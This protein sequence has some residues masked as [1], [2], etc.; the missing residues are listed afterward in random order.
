MIHALGLS[1]ALSV[2]AAVDKVLDVQKPVGAAVGI[3]KDGKLVYEKYY[4]LRNLAKN[5]PVD[6]NTEFN[7]GSVTKQ[8]TASAI[9][10]L[11]ERGK[12]SIDDKLSNYFPSF[13]HA[14]EITLRQ[15][16]N[17]TTGLEDYLEGKKA[18]SVDALS[19]G[20]DLSAVAAAVDVP[21]HFQPGTKW[22]YSNTNYYVLGKVIEKV[23]GQSY[24]ASFASISLRP[25]V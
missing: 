25:P 18:P 7:I 20:G 5:E 4:G 1:T 8:F 6:R 24:E 21:L 13:P 12:L 10:Q 9:L 2:T 11:Q 22:E 3:V 23:S 14:R 15:M 19:H 17:Q 16:L